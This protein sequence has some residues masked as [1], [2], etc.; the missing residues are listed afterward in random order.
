MGRSFHVY[1]SYCRNQSAA[2]AVACLMDLHTKLG[3]QTFARRVMYS[4]VG[5]H[6]RAGYTLCYWSKEV[7][8]LPGTE[9]TKWR[10]FPEG[11]G[12]GMCDAQGGRMRGWLELVSKTKVISDLSTFC[13][14]LQ[15]QAEACET[16]SPLSAK[17]FFYEF[18]P[19]AKNTLP[20]VTLDTKDMHKKSLAL[21]SSYNWTFAQ[22]GGE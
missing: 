2:F 9:T 8:N 5:N 11:H 15:N 14:T 17:S 10:M 16:L 4:D 1:C 12:K 21:K 7:L 19:P 18:D 20:Q 13:R 6:F 3:A 22:E